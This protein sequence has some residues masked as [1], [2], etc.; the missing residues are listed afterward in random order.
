MGNEQKTKRSR[1]LSSLKLTRVCRHRTAYSG[2]AHTGKGL[3]ILD[4]DDRRS[5]TGSIGS[6]DSTPQT[7]G[8]PEGHWPTCWASASRIRPLLRLMRG[9]R[10]NANG[11]PIIRRGRAGRGVGGETRGAGRE[12]AARR[13]PKGAVRQAPH[14]PGGA[15]EAGRGPKYVVTTGKTPVLGGSEWRRRRSCWS[16]ETPGSRCGGALRFG[17]MSV[18]S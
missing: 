14:R 9:S 6:R 7:T 18:S 12:A 3:G 15:N 11:Y 2:I 17:L 10:I 5:K 16:S 4:Q 13:G 1:Y 8:L